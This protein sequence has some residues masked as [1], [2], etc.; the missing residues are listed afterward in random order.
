MEVCPVGIEHI[1]KIVDMRRYLVLMES[2]FPSEVQS[3]FRGMER[4]SNPWGLGRA[5]RGDWAKDL[6]VKILSESDGRV[7]VLFYVGCAGSYD[8]RNQ[9]VAVSMVKILEAAG[10]NFGILGTEEGCCGDSARRIGNEYLFQSM[11]MDL[12]ETINSYGVKKII[13]TCPHGYNCLM[14]EY[15]Q[16]GGNWEVYH[17]SEFLAKL[18]QE[19]RLRPAV[20]M[21]KNL[22][23]HDSCYLGRYNG[24][25][26]EPRMVLKSISGIRN[27]EMDR[28]RNKSFCCGAGGGR[29]WMEETL[30]DEKINDSRTEQALGVEPDIIGV[31]CPFC[32]TMLED[33]LKDRSME[34]KVKVYDIAELL[35][36]TVLQKK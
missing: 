32:T 2:S 23:F 24:I 11:A 27:S 20:G 17:H 4:N 21:D 33:G 18:L 3:T 26:E 10:V 25:Y 8:I 1:D 36:Q 15:P 13:T 31:S 29:M 34:E 7:D 5:T 19:E 12:V 28:S 14:N 35:A 16:F 6:G 22:A 30:G 9:K